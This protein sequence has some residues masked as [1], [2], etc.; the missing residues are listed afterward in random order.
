MN[1]PEC[2]E[3][4]KVID[5][6]ERADGLTVRRRRQCKGCGHRFST[7]ELTAEDSK[8][9]EISNILA[10]PCNKCEYENECTEQVKLV[11]MKENFYCFTEIKRESVRRRTS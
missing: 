9:K 8:I 6:R 4:T 2:G 11:S 7:T 10:R 1:C 3:D 5:S